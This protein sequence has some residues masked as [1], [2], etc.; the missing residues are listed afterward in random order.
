MAPQGVR[1]PSRANENPCKIDAMGL[2]LAA[3]FGTFTCRVLSL[4]CKE[5]R[6]DRFHGQC[7]PQ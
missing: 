3:R 7:C 2:A 5:K 4:G 6:N 1:G